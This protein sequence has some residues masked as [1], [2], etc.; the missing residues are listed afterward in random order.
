[1]VMF[2]CMSVCIKVC[3]NSMCTIIYVY[4]AF[5]KDLSSGKR[6]TDQVQAE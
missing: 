3:I 4:T 5:V 2:I 1:M 6:G